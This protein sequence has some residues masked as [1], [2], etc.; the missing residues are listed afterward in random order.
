MQ[1]DTLIY[2]DVRSPDN[3][4]VAMALDDREVLD[5][6]DFANGQQRYVS[7]PYSA[8]PRADAKGVFDVVL[9][10][11]PV[12]RVLVRFGKPTAKPESKPTVGK[13][14]AKPAFES[15][16]LAAV[17]PGPATLLT[18]I[19]PARLCYEAPG[20]VVQVYDNGL[21]VEHKG[22]AGSRYFELHFAPK[23]VIT[24]DYMIAPLTASEGA[25]IEETGIDLQETLDSMN[26]SQ[27]L[28]SVGDLI[29]VTASVLVGPGKRKTFSRPA[30]IIAVHCPPLTVDALL[31]PQVYGDGPHKF[32]GLTYDEA[33][34]NMTWRYLATQD[35]I[36]D[37][38]KPINWGE[39]K[40][41]VG[42]N[43][44]SE[45]TISPVRMYPGFKRPREAL[46][47]PFWM[48]DDE[49]AVKYPALASMR[50]RYACEP[51][52]AALVTHSKPRVGD[53]VLLDL[54]QGPLYGAPACVTD[55]LTGEN[56]EVMINAAPLSD[57]Y[58]TMGVVRRMVS[59]LR[60]T[61]F[62]EEGGDECWLWP[63]ER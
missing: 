35:D 12:G 14:T 13:P 62:V 47:S 1:N 43:G 7:V 46:K 26:I 21:P 9:K 54:I 49:R 44:P 41:A 16:P 63:G 15:S 29:E 39:A 19:G 6:Y 61:S 18:K 3:S 11:M 37:H 22:A 30:H 31:E 25:T 27:K 38:K 28:P 42:G 40:F 57:I 32:E 56:G 52:K 48:S 23:G 17:V 53:I 24:V 36:K 10:H 51:G 59:C 4:F 34:G 20:P 50:A 60:H 5:V 45:S 2:V 58:S 33:Q 8:S 55:V